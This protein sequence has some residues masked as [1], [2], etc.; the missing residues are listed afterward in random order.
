VRALNNT[1]LLDFSLKAQIT[2]LH[3]KSSQKNA[4]NGILENHDF[5]ISLE[6]HAHK[7]PGFNLAHKF[8]GVNLALV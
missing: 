7:F 1:K 5:K 8:P 6:E 3:V 4:G 2:F